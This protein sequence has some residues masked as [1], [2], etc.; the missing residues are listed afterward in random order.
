MRWVAQ[1]SVGTA[2]SQLH[3]A[4]TDRPPAK[5]WAWPH[6]PLSPSCCW[7]LQVHYY[8]ADGFD[9]M[10]MCAAGLHAGS[11]APG[12]RLQLPP[13]A[14]A[15]CPAWPPVDASTPHSLSPARASA[16]LP[17]CSALREQ[18]GAVLTPE[19]QAAYHHGSSQLY[20]ALKQ[21]VDAQ[22]QKFEQY[23]LETCLHV[24]AGLLAQPV[25]AML[26]HQGPANGDQ[27]GS[28]TC[29]HVSMDGGCSTATCP[30]ACRL[31]LTLNPS[32]C[33]VCR[34]WGLRVRQRWMRLRRRR[35]MSSCTNC[36]GR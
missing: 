16:C 8:R 5:V 22:L 4:R 9:T 23:A 7:R 21:E 12:L 1:A 25:G 33:V 2:A 34:W 18:R 15:P 30:E 27:P 35:W 20:L 14:H 19:Q 29:Q 24:P 11:A 10:D 28:S 17:A 26:R 6:P 13:A 36:G 32:P 31:N 3:V